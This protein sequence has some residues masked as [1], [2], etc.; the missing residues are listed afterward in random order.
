MASTTCC[1]DTNGTRP[2]RRTHKAN[3]RKSGFYDSTK[4]T[5]QRP[6]TA[7]RIGKQPLLRHRLGRL[8]RRS[9]VHILVAAYLL[10]QYLPYTFH[11]ADGPV[12]LGSPLAD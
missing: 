6:E 12:P 10:L 9:R 8:G 11:L 3:K 4:G 2:T 1:Q 7:S 5:N